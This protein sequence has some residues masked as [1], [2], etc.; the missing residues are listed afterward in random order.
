MYDVTFG[1]DCD[2][3][4]WVFTVLSTFGAFRI[5]IGAYM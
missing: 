5:V 1:D 3:E 4:E 2:T